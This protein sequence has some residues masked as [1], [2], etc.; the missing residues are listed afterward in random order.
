MFQKIFSM[1]VT[2]ASAL[3]IAYM[4]AGACEQS[5]NGTLNTGVIAYP[6]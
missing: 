5:R 1:I 2:F 4:L 3:A 6:R